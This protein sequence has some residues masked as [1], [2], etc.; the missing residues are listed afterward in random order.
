MRGQWHAV[1]DAAANGFQRGRHVAEERIRIGE[2]EVGGRHLVQPV[3]LQHLRAARDHV[4]RI[5]APISR[6]G[7]HASRHRVLIPY[8]A[9]GI[10]PARM[11]DQRNT[12]SL[13]EGGE[14]LRKQRRIGNEGG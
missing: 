6:I 13:L 9:G 1:D 5:V 7:C 4:V 12:K 10:D 11:G 2:I 3:L 8:G 14:A